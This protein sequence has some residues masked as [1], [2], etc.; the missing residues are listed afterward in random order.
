M[1]CEAAVRAALMKVDGVYDAKADRQ[2]KSAWVKY[3]TGKTTPE[4]LVE[5]I[6]TKTNYKAS[7]K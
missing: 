1:L 6:N 3:N 4:K 5:A 7:L 2:K